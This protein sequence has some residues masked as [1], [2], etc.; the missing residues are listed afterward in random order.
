M[1]LDRLLEGV[2]G[3]AGLLVACGG[4]AEPG[5]VEEDP[6]NEPRTGL[7]A[8]F[9]AGTDVD[10][11]G[12]IYGG[13]FAYPESD[14][15]ADT[16]GGDLHVTGTVGD[17]PG[18]GVWFGSCVNASEYSGV[19]FLLGGSLGTFRELRFV[20]DTRENDPAPP[21]TPLGTCQP[22]DPSM[23]FA[24]CLPA[25]TQVAL[26]PSPEEVVI[27]FDRLTQ[28]IPNPTVDPSQ[29]TGM[30]LWFPWSTGSASYD[31]DVR[32]DDIAFIR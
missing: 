19:R 31:V 25:I 27:P 16:N 23:P 15:F 13:V 29:I 11:G 20:I 21:V 4:T 8:D 1:A 14:L 26:P 18:I 2:A 6:C 32:L 5:T 22:S 28:G 9:T 12:G 30:S 24:D 7:I 3:I 17:Y 10:D